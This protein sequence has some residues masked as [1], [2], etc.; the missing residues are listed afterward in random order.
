MLQ[1]R[2]ATVALWIIAIV[3][4]INLI[5]DVFVG[6]ASATGGS[7][8]RVSGPVVVRLDRKL[9]YLGTL[10]IDL[11]RIRGSTTSALPIKIDNCE[12]LKR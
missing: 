3:L 9:D 6:Y 7:A 11:D 10:K 12:C 4:L 5:K 1:S 8:V 2:S